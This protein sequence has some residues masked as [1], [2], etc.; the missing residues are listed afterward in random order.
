MKNN[1]FS[2][3]DAM[4]AA[5]FAALIAIGAYI[6]IPLPGTPVPIVFQN[7]FIFLAALVLGPWWA[8][9]SVCFYLFLGA[10]GFPVF[11]GGSGGI[12]KLFGPTGGYLFGFIPSVLAAGA[13]SRGLKHTIAGNAAACAIGLL[14]VYASGVFWLKE[15]ISTDWGRA[16]AAGVLPFILGDVAKIA[17]SVALAPRI[18]AGIESMR[19]R[20]L[21]A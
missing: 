3:T 15:A 4:L 9:V 7:M 13:I 1:K 10:I 12:A 8:L 21:D 16:L 17:L 14:I 11:S 19:E 2:L 20:E 18:R 6:A 5:M